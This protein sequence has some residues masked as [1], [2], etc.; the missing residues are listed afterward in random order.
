M[1]GPAPTPNPRRRNAR[2][3]VVLLPAEGYRGPLPAWPLSTRAT[4]AEQT[5]WAELWRLPQGQA[6]AQLNLARQVA[7]YVRTL[8]RA[9]QRGATASLVATAHKLGE[10]IG[11]SAMAM[12]RLRWEVARDELADQRDQHPAGQASRWADLKVVDGG[13]G[14]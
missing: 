4:K 3:G 8:V 1:P 7:L 9:E 10:S 5:A 13:A 6:W 2:P 12:L 11:L 14:S